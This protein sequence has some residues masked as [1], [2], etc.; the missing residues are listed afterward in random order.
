[1][2]VYKQLLLKPFFCA[3]YVCPNP[4]GP[5][6]LGW[7][8]NKIISTIFQVQ[9][10]KSMK[11]RFPVLLL[12]LALSVLG[13]P[14]ESPF[15][16]DEPSI[17]VDNNLL[18]S[19]M[20]IGEMR[21][22]T[23]YAVSKKSEFQYQ[24]KSEKKVLE[25]LPTITEFVAHISNVGANKFVNIIRDMREEAKY[26]IYNVKSYDGQ[27]ILTELNSDIK[28]PIQSSEELKEFIAKYMHLSFFYGIE[29]VLNKQR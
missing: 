3:I 19:W 9:F 20:G 22:T 7:E 29:M 28:E 4:S 24:V 11:N 23:Y 27:I 16:I 13:C 1:M 12:L 15:P 2:F 25:D 17:K 26:M 18:G 14:Y 6:A 21:D 5:Q 10:P 8:A